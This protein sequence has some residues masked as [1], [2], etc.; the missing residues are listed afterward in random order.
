LGESI[1]MEVRL[2]SNGTTPIQGDEAYDTDN[3]KV[4][5]YD[6]GNWVPMYPNTLEKERILEEF[7]KNPELYNE[8]MVEM[9]NRKIN[10][11]K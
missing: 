1:T 7:E 10:K 4:L 5:V 8:V 9:R 6:K 11:F 2:N 3:G